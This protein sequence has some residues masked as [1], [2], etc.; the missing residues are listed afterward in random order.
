MFTDKFTEVYEKCFPLKSYKFGYKTRK[1]WLTEGLKNSIDRKNNF[2]GSHTGQ[3]KK[4]PEFSLR[5]LK[6]PEL[7]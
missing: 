2:Q 7:L 1:P 6:I 5:Y 3:H 4:F